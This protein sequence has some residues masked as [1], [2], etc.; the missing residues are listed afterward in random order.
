MTYTITTSSPAAS[1]K[2]GER[3]GALLRGG[4]IIEL[5]GDLGGGKTTLTSGLARGLGYSGEVTSPTFTLNHIYDLPDGRQLHHFDFYRLEPGDVA[6][7]QLAESA[8]RSDVITVVE[9]AGNAGAALPQERLTLKL[10][11]TGVTT[12]DITIE[13]SDR[14][15][16]LIEALRGSDT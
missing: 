6:A 14:Y 1:S 10:D 13:G 2:L 12:R 9:W 5:A 4:E 16:S 8:G 7:S 15:A 3:I 11:A